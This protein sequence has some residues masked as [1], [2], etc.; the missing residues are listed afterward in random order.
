MWVIEQNASMKV[1]SQLFV[2]IRP[3]SRPEDVPLAFATPYEGNAACKKRQETV[4]NWLGGRQERIIKNGRYTDEYVPR[5]LNT[6]ILDNVPREGFK[7]TDDVKRVYW[8]GGNVV[9]RVEDP[10]G[11]ELEIQS[12]NLMAIIQCAGIAPGG[13]ILGKCL[14]GRSGK[15]NILLH[16]TSE[17]YKNAVKAAETVKP[18]P[19]VK[20]AERKPGSIYK[21]ANGLG[22]LYA[23]KVY[24]TNVVQEQDLNAESVFKVRTDTFTIQAGTHCFLETQMRPSVSEAYDACIDVTKKDDGTFERGTT[25]TLYKK[26][27]LV[28][29][30]VEDHISL[31]KM[32]NAWLSKF[33]GEFAA[34][35]KDWKIARIGAITRQPFVDPVF[36]LVPLSPT[37]T[38]EVLDSYGLSRTNHYDHGKKLFT[39]ADAAN[40]L[41]LHDAHH[42][43][44]K[45][46][47][48]YT[49]IHSLDEDTR[50][51]Y[52]TTRVDPTG[53]C[54]LLETNFSPDVFTYRSFP[55]NCYYRY[56]HY[57]LRPT[58][59]KADAKTITVGAFKTRNE[60][61]EHVRELIANGGLMAITLVER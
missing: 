4:I 17:E 47:K 42:V 55:H 54:M 1:F 32:N 8:G 3:K 43:L 25:I 21:L 48:V 57:S 30:V 38:K 26:A 56:N 49:G 29:L 36:K 5:E 16:E 37:Q 41:K 50:W 15:D 52:M 23:G 12:Q 39:Y 9:W 14:W 2:G 58:D 28:D 59:T 53:E 11:F 45:D 20:K 24:V 31:D 19:K 35:G 18:P 6:P 46:G 22:M 7:I 13:Q 51:S 27:P 34:A 60:L 33:R 44:V 10:Y 61:R 40:S